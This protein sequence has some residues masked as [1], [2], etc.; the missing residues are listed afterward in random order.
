MSKNTKSFI[1]VVLAIIYIFAISTYSSRVNERSRMEAMDQGFNIALD[2]LQKI[3]DKQLKADKNTLT[4][5][6]FETPKDTL[7]YI[8][9]HKE[10]C[11]N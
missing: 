9:K 5:I 1:L 6:V 3:V 11:K 10:N 4:K 7:T 8:L 2:T